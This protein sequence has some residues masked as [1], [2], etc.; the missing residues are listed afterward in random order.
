[1]CNIGGNHKHNLSCKL[2][3]SQMSRQ[4]LIDL[5][6]KQG[7][8]ADVSEEEGTGY[9]RVVTEDTLPNYVKDTIQ[10]SVPAGVRVNFTTKVRGSM[11][12]PSPLAKWYKATKGF[13]K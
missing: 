8:K 3:T 2:Y 12:C 5:I 10:A 4:E 6:L 9:V 11:A 7:Y 1:M 13:M